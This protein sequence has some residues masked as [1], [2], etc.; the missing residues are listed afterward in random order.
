MVDVSKAGTRAVGAEFVL[1]LVVIGVGIEIPS[2]AS[3]T[4]IFNNGD[5]N[6]VTIV[7]LS[8]QQN[9]NQKGTNVSFTILS[10]ETNFIGDI[11]Q[12]CN[13]LVMIN[14]IQE[15]LDLQINNLHRRRSKHVDPLTWSKI[16]H[17]KF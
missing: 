8:L 14:V 5:V 2:E 12:D 7:E 6:R 10:A 9:F 16:Q 17:Q 1:E 3:N 11:D 4:A 13:L 15:I